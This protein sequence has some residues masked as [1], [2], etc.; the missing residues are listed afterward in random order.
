MT[1]LL[2][3]M[4]LL[5]A[6]IPTSADTLVVRY[7]TP[8]TITIDVRSGWQVNAHVH[9]DGAH[10]IVRFENLRQAGEERYPEVVIDLGTDSLLVWDAATHWFHA[11]YRDCDAIGRFNAYETCAPTRPGWTANNFPA[12]TVEI[13]ISLDLLGITQGSNTTGR[14]AL[15]VTDTR[16]QY[17]FWPRGA[18]LE[19]IASWAVLISPDSWIGRAQ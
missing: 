15:N 19:N 16:T 2:L 5:L 10:L 7:D 1:A 18:T 4:L 14:I 13:K 8:T 11:S 9:H 12:D 17:H 6:A 3:P